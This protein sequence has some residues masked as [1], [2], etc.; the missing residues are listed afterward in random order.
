MSSKSIVLAPSH[1]YAHMLKTSRHL[2]KKKKFNGNHL[3]SFGNQFRKLSPLEI[4]YTRAN[5]Q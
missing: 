4:I 2:A 3:T 5:D 1:I